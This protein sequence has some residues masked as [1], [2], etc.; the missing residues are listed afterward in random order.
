VAEEAAVDSAAEAATGMH[1]LLSDHGSSQ[2][3]RD[4]YREGDRH[5]DRDSGYKR[6]RDQDDQNDGGKFG[7]F[8]DKPYRAKG[9]SQQNDADDFKDKQG[10]YGYKDPL[11]S[12]ATFPIERE[13]R[14]GV[15]KTRGGINSLIQAAS[16]QTQTASTIS[17]HQNRCQTACVKQRACTIAAIVAIVIT[18]VTLRAEDTVEVVAEA[19]AVEVTV[20][21]I[22]VTETETIVMSVEVAV[23]MAVVVVAEAIEVIAIEVMTTGYA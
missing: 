2:R 15:V 5:K 1:L 6:D 4:D 22:V 9:H 16:Q 10:K 23:A 12:P 21:A 19:I 14:S 3:G 17:A 13:G 7:A 20:V 8:E 11:Q 18:V